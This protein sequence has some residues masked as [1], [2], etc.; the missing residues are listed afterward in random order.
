MSL[1]SRFVLINVVR[2]QPPFSFKAHLVSVM[3]AMSNGRVKQ[4]LALLAAIYRFAPE[5][6]LHPDDIYRPSSVPWYL[7]HLRMRR[8]RPGAPDVHILH[9]GEVTVRS[10]VSQSSGGQESGRGRQRTDFLV[11]IVSIVPET[12]RGLLGVAECYVHLRPA[13]TR[14]AWDIQYWFFYAYN[15]DISRGAD[16]EHEGDFEHVTVRV[17]PD[18]KT[19]FRVF[20]HAHNT[21]SVWRAGRDVTF[22]GGTHPVA[23]SA[24]HTHATY[25]RSGTHSRRLLPDDHTAN[26]GP[27]WR[28][29]SSLRLLGHRDRPTAGQEWIHYTGH[30]GQIGTKISWLSGPFG[31]AFQG[32]W[33]ND[34]DGA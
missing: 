26:G 23:F 6:R 1:S 25:W 29:W 21:E 12:R 17:A 10:L 9:P 33:D 32:Y 3:G 22:S 27:I 4:A 13:P 28:T 2:A 31:P 11:E 24:K 34:D 30:W 14:D 18:G 19:M 5:V 16:F 7:Q 8:H 20:Y 15:G